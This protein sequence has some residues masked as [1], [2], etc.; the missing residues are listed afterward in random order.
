MEAEP[1]LWA[2]PPGSGQNTG[3]GAGAGVGQEGSARLQGKRVNRLA[4]SV[5]L[6]LCLSICS[7]EL[8]QLSE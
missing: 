2:D 4:F 1:L 7:V 5:R 8:T 6:L 3:A